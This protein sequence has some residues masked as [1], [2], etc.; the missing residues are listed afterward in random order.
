M[1]NMKQED[2]QKLLRSMS[3]KEKVDQM[4]QLNG[5]FYQEDV[6]TVLTG[7]AAHLGLEKEDVR[8][9]GS[10]LGT[11]GAEAL[12]KIQKEYQHDTQTHRQVLR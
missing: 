1:H 4:L 3:L 11:P 9:A 7:P 5:S 10:I 12:K 2:L 8:Q 6:N